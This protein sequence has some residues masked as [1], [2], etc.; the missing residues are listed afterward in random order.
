MLRD[1]GMRCIW[2]RMCRLL[3]NNGIVLPVQNNMM[4]M[5]M[6]LPIRQKQKRDTKASCVLTTYKII[7]LLSEHYIIL[8]PYVYGLVM[9]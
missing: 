4:C 5:L 1:D 7:K 8:K 3:L 6:F 2:K 9:C